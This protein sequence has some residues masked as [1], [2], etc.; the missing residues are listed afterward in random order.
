MT[1]TLNTEIRFESG[2]DDYGRS[3]HTAVTV[4]GREVVG[5]IAK[6]PKTTFP[7]PT[8]LVNDFRIT[9]P[10]LGTSDYMAAIKHVGSLR[11]AKALLTTMDT[12]A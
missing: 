1:T 9:R 6:L 4:D 8:Y 11:E 5:R 7:V 2:R 3:I 12:P 10:L